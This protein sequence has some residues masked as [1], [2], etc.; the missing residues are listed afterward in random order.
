MNELVD[1]DNMKILFVKLD[2]ID[3]SLARNLELEYLMMYPFIQQEL[4]RR[5]LSENFKPE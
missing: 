3:N 1:Q 5:K 2:N 4:A